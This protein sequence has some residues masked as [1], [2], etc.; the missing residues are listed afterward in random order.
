MGEGIDCCYVE[1]FDAIDSDPN[2]ELIVAENSGVVIGTL[3]ITFSPNLTHRGAL[4]GTIEGVRVSSCCRSMGVGTE[5]LGWAIER[6][7]SRNCRIVQLTSDLTRIDAISFYA[8]FGFEHT[9][10][11]M[12]LRI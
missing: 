2:N 4:R 12:K 1:A 7:R 10:A 8:E 11:G 9:H 5:M 6:C 3:Q